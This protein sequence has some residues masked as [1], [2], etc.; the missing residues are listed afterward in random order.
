MERGLRRSGRGDGP[1]GVTRVARLVPVFASVVASVSASFAEEIDGKLYIDNGIVRL[2]ADLD[3]GGGSVFHFSKSPDGPNLLNHHDRGRYIQQSYYGDED[4]SEW[5]GR[6]WRWNPVQ[7]G[8]WK[9]RPATVLERES[10]TTTLRVVSTP[11]NWGGGEDVADARM[12]QRI[13]LDGDVAHIAYRF[14]YSG[15]RRHAPRHQEMP[16]VF[17][18]YALPNLI[19]YDGPNPW[20]GEEPRGIVPG[21]PNRQVDRTEEWSAY[22]DADGRGVGVYTPGSPTIT[23]YR[24]EGDPGPEGSGCSYFA[25]VRT[26]AIEPGGVVE[27]DV[28]LTIG[29]IA[30]IRDRF[31]RIRAANEARPSP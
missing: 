6:P 26:L 12:E 10:T 19:F 7:G 8:H 24:Y 21:W 16:A 2:G 28:Y 5:A 11:V 18:D 27:Y 31:A 14:A 13:R 17:V 3:K 23:C 15:E 4:G 1:M 30:E 20:T 25:P 9:G 22:V 29:P